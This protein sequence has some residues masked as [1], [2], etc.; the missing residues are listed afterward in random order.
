MDEHIVMGPRVQTLGSS[1]RYLPTLPT[2]VPCALWEIEKYIMDLAI[3]Q[4]ISTQTFLMG[5]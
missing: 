1:L 3:L 4:K 2:K 5:S